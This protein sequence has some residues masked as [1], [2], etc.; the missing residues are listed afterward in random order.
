ME[1]RLPQDKIAK[2]LDLIAGFLSVGAVWPATKGTTT[3]PGMPS[4]GLGCSGELIPLIRSSIAP[5]TWRA[6]GK[7]WDE[8]C[9]LAAEKPVGDSGSLRL[10]V[11][12]AFLARL[13]ASGVSGAVARNRL[14]GVAF[15]FKL[16][17]WPVS[18]KH[19]LIGQVLKGWRRESVRNDQRRPIS[20][21]LLSSLVKVSIN[22]CDS[23]YEAS[24]ISAAFGLAFFGTMRVSEILPSSRCRAGG[25]QLDDM[26]ICDDGLRVRVRRSKTDQESRGTWFPLFAIGGAVCPLALIKN[27]MQVRSSGS[28]LFIH[29]N[30]SPFLSCQ[31]LAVLRHALSF[32]G[33]PAADFGTHSFRI[34][35]A[36]EASR[37][38]LFEADIQRVGRWRSRCFTRYIRPELVIR[39]AAQHMAGGSFF[40]LLGSTACGTTPRRSIAGSCRN[41]RYLE[42]NKGTYLVSSPSGSCV[43]RKSR[44]FAD[45]GGYSCRW[46]RPGFFSSRE[47]VDPDES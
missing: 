8:W 33:L 14:S 20:F 9:S 34:G 27:F 19:F 22:V 7:A 23:I 28:Q 37:A 45:S 25:L 42:W 39:Y 2:L 13:Q 6:Y 44:V 32:L 40:H 26:V 11:T 15:H 12:L 1:F 24:L 4:F 18:T 16:R 31:F 38:G 29:E 5:S 41:G 43:Y 30:G 10:Q 17:E 47:T 21:Q 35:A 46:E 3:N 36:T